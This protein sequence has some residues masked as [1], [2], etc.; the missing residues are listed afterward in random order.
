MGEI[1]GP[2]SDRLM[3]LIAAVFPGTYVQIEGIWR[4]IRVEPLPQVGQG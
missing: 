2:A 4:P 1:L 3:R